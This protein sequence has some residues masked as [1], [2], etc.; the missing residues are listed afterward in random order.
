MSRT[1]PAPPGFGRSTTLAGKAFGVLVAAGL[2]CVPAL[3]PITVETAP[4]TVPLA[5]PEADAPVKI[6]YLGSIAKA[7]DVSARRGFWSRLGDLVV[8]RPD[9]RVTA[10]TRPFA[11]AVDASGRLFVADPGTP[12]VHVFDVA[13]KSHDVL[14]GPSRLPLRSPIGVDV[15]GAGNVYVSDSKTGRIYVFDSKG[16]FTRFIGEM[17]DEGYFKRPTGL[18]VDR[19]SGSIYLADTL[20]HSVY[21]VSTAGTIERSWGHRGDG[22]GEFNFP[23]AVALAPDRVFVLD[24][25]NFRVQAFTREGRYLNAF[26]HA[27]NEPGGFFR[28]K[29]LAVDSANGVVLV[30][31]AMFEAVQAFTYDGRLVWAFGQGG[32][33]GG[34]FSLPAGILVQPDGRMVVADS[35]NGR[36]QTFRVRHG[37]RQ[38]GAER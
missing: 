2:L 4:A 26:G 29:G 32:R 20:Q 34:E 13:N 10:L 3:A 37:S 11:I 24:S 31:D 17:K 7:E 35:Y 36:I 14:R 8:G 18:A 5:W 12:G 27:A 6:E 23:T 19:S 21:V 33:E 15:D 28:P 1:T 25:M 22:P 9:T 30:V 16:R 38:A